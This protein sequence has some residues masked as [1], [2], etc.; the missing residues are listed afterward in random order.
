MTEPVF[1]VP[2]RLVVLAPHWV[3]KGSEI[4]IRVE[5]GGSFMINKLG[6]NWAGDKGYLSVMTDQKEAHVFLKRVQSLDGIE[7]SLIDK[8]MFR[9]WGL[10]EVLGDHGYRPLDEMVFSETNDPDVLVGD[11]V[12]RKPR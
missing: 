4:T 1:E 6:R 9:N 11:I 3:D 12:D 2:V 7:C 10:D 8:Y 5:G